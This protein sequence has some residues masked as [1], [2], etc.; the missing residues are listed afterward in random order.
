MSSQQQAIPEINPWLIAIAVMSS[1]FM[2][3]LDTTVVN[4][5]LP[6]I[7][8]SLSATI[9][10][11]TW[12]LTSYLVANAIVLPMTGWLA[13]R[14][15]RKRLLML[16]VTGFTAASFACGLAPSLGFLI[17][18][19][20]IQGACGGG[21]QPLSQAILLESFPP[22]KRGQAMAFWALGIVVAPMLGPVLGGWL[23]DNYSWRW[24]FYINVPIGAIAILLTQAFIFDPPY[25][26]R[27]RTGI[28]YWG[29][30]MLVVGIGCLQIMLDKGQEEDWFGSR[31]IIT[32][33]V[34][35]VLGLGGLIIRELKAAHPVIDLSVFRYRSYAVGTFLMTIVGFV[36]YGS[37]VLLPLLMQE[38]LGYTATHAGI[39]NLPRGLASFLFMPVVGILTGKVDSRKLLAAGLTATAGAMFAVSFFSLDVGFWNFWWP[40]M[41]QGAGL[42]LI[43]VPLTTVTNDPIPREHMGNAT[44]VFNLMRNIGASVGISIVETLQFRHMQA[45]I[46]YLSGHVNS[47]SLQAQ[48]ALAGFQRSF[49]LKGADSVT[50][51]RQAHGALWGMLLQQASMLSYNDVFRFLGG[52]FI[53]MLPLLF[54]ME[55]PKGSKGPAM[56]H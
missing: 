39:T 12:T 10:E 27:E 50:A 26:R 53:L 11:A 9:D 55:K 6:H 8:G 1:T 46:N 5:S 43:F 49:M 33:T 3:V 56:A 32:L 18:F 22:H 35:A 24:V 21:L 16:A 40:L 31:F 42:G 2:E 34:L 54:L 20:C 13:G 47:T 52:M 41:L 44:S 17:I 38:L 7:A 15:G 36:L 28:D 30:G 4:V 19:R 51:M 45:H 25:L 14:F 48:R 37:T 29:I 23:T